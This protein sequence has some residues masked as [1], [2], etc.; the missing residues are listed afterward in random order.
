MGSRKRTIM[1]SSATGKG[2][3]Q[4][5]DEMN[6]PISDSRDY[7]GKTPTLTKPSRKVTYC[8]EWVQV[9]LAG[10]SLTVE[11]TEVIVPICTK[12]LSMALGDERLVLR[13]LSFE[14]AR[15]ADPLKAFENAAQ[16]WDL[17]HSGVHVANKTVL[18]IPVSKSVPK[19]QGS[20]F[21]IILPENEEVALSE[22]TRNGLR[23]RSV[24]NP[25]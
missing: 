12:L 10:R 19:E 18:R 15:S 3:S 25:R 7:S 16:I 1:P 4:K 9:Q 8:V 5:T 13:L 21:A 22:T 20:P 6:F 24:T 11:E 23:N 17:D 14:W 2:D